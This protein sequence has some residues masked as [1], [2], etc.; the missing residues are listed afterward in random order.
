MLTAPFNTWWP[1]VAL[2]QILESYRAIARVKGNMSQDDKVNRIKKVGEGEGETQL[3][4]TQRDA[5][6]SQLKTTHSIN[7][8]ML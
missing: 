8:V 7:K 2:N 4:G 6:T 1:G 5:R 3:V